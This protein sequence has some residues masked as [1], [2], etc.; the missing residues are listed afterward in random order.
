MEKPIGVHGLSQN[1]LGLVFEHVVF[2]P[3]DLIKEPWVWPS[4]PPPTTDSPL[5]LLLLLFL[6]IIIRT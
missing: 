1:T 6:L 5:F 4:N 2:Q 3:V